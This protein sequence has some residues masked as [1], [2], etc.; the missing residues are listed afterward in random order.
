M[1]QRMEFKLY[2]LYQLKQASLVAEEGELGGIPKQ[3]PHV[4][5]NPWFPFTLSKQGAGLSLK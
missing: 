2:C 3:A 1:S 4:S 5:E